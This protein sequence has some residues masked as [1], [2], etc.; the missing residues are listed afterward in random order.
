MQAM[1]DSGSGRT[2]I[3]KLAAQKS[4]LY[5]IPKSRTIPLADKKS[6]AKIIGE[7]VINVV[8]NGHEHRGVVAEVI[9]DLCTDI[10]I[11]R[12]IQ[13]KHRRVVLNFNGP[14]DELV[15]GAMPNENNSSSP[16]TAS[17]TTTEISPPPKA[18]TSTSTSVK[19][20]AMNVPPP[21]LFTN[22][23]N[24]IK[25]IAT[26]SRRQSPAN[27]RFI[28]A[29]VSKLHK[30][31]TIR[32]SVS[33]WRAQAFI[34]K[35]DGAHKKR[36]VIDYSE[37]INLF[38]ELDAY[39]MPSVPKMV[40]DISQYKYF[41]TFDLKSAY[42]QV[43][44]REEDRKYTAFEADGKLW[45]FTTVPFGVTNGVSAF[46]RTID[47]VLEVEGV[48][49]TFAFVDNV[50]VCGRT[51]EEHDRNVLAF[52]KVRD[53]YNIT[54]NDEKTIECT[55]SLTTLGYVISNNVI[56]PDSNRLKPLLEM[57]P[58]SNLKSQKRI[59]GMFA[60]YSKFIE[61]F[62]QKIRSLNQNRI[63][64]LPPPA[65]EAFQL[66][67]NNLKDAA[68]KPVD[69]EGEFVIE[70]DA[71]DFCIA[72]TLNQQGRPVAFFSR[73][74]NQSEIGHHAVEKEAAAIVESI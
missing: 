12:D 23:S 36:M 52:K 30:A 3:S 38:T 35:E 43:P 10:I 31:G 33:P 34:T 59:V 1:V 73:T 37:T 21:P 66:L 8:I 69:P 45:E 9:K 70:T 61:N 58:P 28:K 71:S 29:E 27:L 53:K 5:I 68:L 19:F 41:S 7:V 17:S 74:L 56:S 54:L 63:F 46:Q 4:N 72:A 62:S 22:L 65:L 57:P 13:G 64:P 44:I 47:K 16:T 55:T 15:I 11:G 32:P 18:K 14:R 26:K 48:S 60:Y 42:H 6:V 51:K 2:F 24:N 39:P 49:D 25:P 50:H 67:K 40:Q 20:G